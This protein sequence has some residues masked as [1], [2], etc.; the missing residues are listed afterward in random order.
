MS[1]I[2]GNPDPIQYRSSRK[3]VLSGTEAVLP[4]SKTEI[5]LF[6]QTP[7]MIKELYG[8]LGFVRLVDMMPR[9]VPNGRTADIAIT[10]NAR[11]SY[12]PQIGDKTPAEDAKL[13]GY[14]IKNKHTSPLESVVFQFQMKIPIFVER[15]LI[16][17]RTARVNEQ[18]MRYTKADDQFFMP[19]LR[20][21][22]KSN[23]QCSSTELVPDE[24]QQV[25]NEI[26]DDVAGLYE[27]YEKLVAAGVARE[28]A[29][30]C[31]PVSLM[32]TVMWQMD[33]HN[34]SHFLK[35]RM[36]PD[37]QKEIRELAEAIFELVYPYVP[38]SMD[39][40]SLLSKG[41]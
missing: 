14:L 2:Q 27:K 39:T 32:T 7:P 3:E 33:L 19:E 38:V 29:R 41:S 8:G 40:F 10:R 36:A 31:L 24:L 28:V 22:S 11:V 26:I 1:Q 4:L 16:R 25:R 20:M 18:S 34:L 6:E 13:V 12:N 17:H 9:I 5:D 37:A 15:Q 21:Q 30:C 35:L 23:K